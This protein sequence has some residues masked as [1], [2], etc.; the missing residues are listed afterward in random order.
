M[1]VTLLSLVLGT[2]FALSGASKLRNPALFREALVG[3]YRFPPSIALALSRTVPVAEVAIGGLAAYPG[4]RTIGLA[5]A[6]VV[7][8]AIS[9]VVAIA[10]V[11]GRRGDCGCFVGLVSQPLDTR[12]M[13]R[14]AALLAFALIAYGLSIHVID[15]SL[16]AGVEA[17]PWIMLSVIGVIAI[18]VALYQTLELTIRM[19]RDRGE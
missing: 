5:L 3:T 11:S 10:L 6:A 15:A 9:A 8:M 1:L 19:R 17:A 12:T 4:T 2:V 18:A 7:L 16:V 14:S 13:V